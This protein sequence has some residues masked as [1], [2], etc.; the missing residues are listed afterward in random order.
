MIIRAGLTPAT[1]RRRDLPPKLGGGIRTSSSRPPPRTARRRPS[2]R[3]TKPV[4]LP[5][6]SSGNQAVRGNSLVFTFKVSAPT[7]NACV[8]HPADQPDGD[9][10]EHDRR[11]HLVDAALHLQRSGDAGPD[12]A[13]RHRQH[14]AERHMQDGGKVNLR[15]DRCRDQHRESS[16]SLD[17][18]VEQVHLEPDGDSDARQDQRYCALAAS[19]NESRVMSYSSI[20]L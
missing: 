19:R 18:D 8:E 4:S 3:R 15:P 5:L 10:V 11:D 2:R 12:R 13:D 14:Q 6:T 16:L 17:A 20:C 1:R 9:V 7:T